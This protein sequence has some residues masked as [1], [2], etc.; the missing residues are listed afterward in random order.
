ME[1]LRSCGYRQEALRLAVAVVRT[2]KRQQLEW[3]Y[4]KGKEQAL[5]ESMCHTSFDF[6]YYQVNALRIHMRHSK[7]F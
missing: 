7:V 5:L 2:M 6:F 1:A 4:K 3:Q